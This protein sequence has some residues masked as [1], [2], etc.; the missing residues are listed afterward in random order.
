MKIPPTIPPTDSWAVMGLLSW[1]LWMWNFPERIDAP[2]SKYL[3]VP[4]HF[5]PLSSREVDKALDTAGRLFLQWGHFRQF[6]LYGHW[7]TFK[8]KSAMWPVQPAREFG[9]RTAAGLVV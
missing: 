6:G 5:L 3:E 9:G 1:L 8:A 2:D 4:T 7:G